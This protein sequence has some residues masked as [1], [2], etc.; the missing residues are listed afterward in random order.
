M[1]Q[2]PILIVNMNP[3]DYFA[4]ISSI[5]P[6]FRF[7]KPVGNDEFNYTIQ[8]TALL[9]NGHYHPAISASVLPVISTKLNRLHRQISKESKITGETKKFSFYF[10]LEPNNIH[11]IH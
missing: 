2:I 11:S 3:N 1:I 5:S 10:L 9:G 6:I 4:S 8:D 7:E